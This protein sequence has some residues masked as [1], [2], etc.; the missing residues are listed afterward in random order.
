[1]LH[2]IYRDN[3]NHPAIAETLSNLGIIYEALGKLDEAH[4]TQRKCL[5][6]KR[7]IYGR[8]PRELGQYVPDSGK[9]G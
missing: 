9:V 3:T 7:A 1:M 2:A 5:V 8:H 6:M 4:A